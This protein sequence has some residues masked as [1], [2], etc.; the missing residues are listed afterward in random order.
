MT[1]EN[2][3]LVGVAVFCL[4]V[5]LAGPSVAGAVQKGLNA[6]QVDGK[7]AVGAKAPVAKRKNKLVAT[8]KQG[9]LPDNIIKRARDAAKLGGKAASSYKAISISW[10]A[11]Q[12]DSTAVATNTGWELPDGEAVVGVRFSFT[13]PPSYTAGS[14]VALDL[15]L[16]K[17]TLG[18]CTIVLVTLGSGFNATSNQAALIQFPDASSSA[19]VDVGDQT[20]VSV[21]VTGDDTPLKP[22]DTV[23]VEAV[24]LGN[25]GEDVCFAGV[26][27]SGAQVRF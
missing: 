26:R 3:K 12:A 11:M 13:L 14:P 9:Y 2:L 21:S 20:V 10:A 27:V 19:P 25:D 18:S 1:R 6:D 4:T 23:T 15:T 5:G 24:R 22:R 8:N 7:H 17:P 16:S